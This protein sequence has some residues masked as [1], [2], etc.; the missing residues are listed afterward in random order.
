MCKCRLSQDRFFILTPKDCW[1]RL[2]S[3]GELEIVFNALS[4]GLLLP[5]ICPGAPGLRTNPIGG[6]ASSRLWRSH[7]PMVV[8]DS[9]PNAGKVFGPTLRPEVL[10]RESAPPEA[11]GL[12]GV[13][14][15]GMGV[16]AGTRPQLCLD[17]WVRKISDPWV[18]A[19]VS[20]GYRLQFRRRPPPFS[21]VRMTLVRDPVQAQFLKRE[22]LILLQKDA[23]MKVDPSEQLAG[24]YS[25]YFLVPKK[26]G[27]L[28][29]ILDLRR[30]NTFMKVLPFKMLTTNQVLESLE[31]GEWF[32]SIDLKDAY[33]HVPIFP[34]HWPFL[35]FAFQGQ[36]YQFKVLPFG[37]SLSPRVF[38][39]VVGAALSPL[40]L[41]G[42]KILPY[43][44]DWLVCAPSPSQVSEDTRSLLS[45]IQSLGFT[46]NVKKS[47]LEPRQQAV[48][49]GLCL[50]SVTMSASLTVQRVQSILTLLVQFQLGRRVKLV[51]FQRLLGMISAAVAVVPLGLLRAQPLQRWLNALKLHPKV[52]R[53]VKI[54]VSRTCLQ[55]LCPWQDQ[56]LLVQGVP[57]GLIPSRRTVVTTDASLT[58][59]GGV[60]EGRMVRG[61][62]EPPW[63]EA[64]INVLELRACHL[65]LKALLPFIRDKHVLVRTDSSCT[66]Y[67]INHQGGTR[68][69]QCLQVT[70]EL[71]FWAIQHLASLRAI[72]IPGVLNRAADLLSRSGPPPGEWRLHPE[73]VALLWTRYGRARTDL[74]ASTVTT[75]CKMWFSML[76][77][78]G[79]LGLDALSREWPE[80][81]LY[82]F[83]PF[84]LLPKVLHRVAIG[85]YK[86]LLI[87][88]RWPRRHWF[89][90]LLR[91]VYGEPWALP[92][93]ADLLSQ[94]EGQ[95][96]HPKPAILQLWAW[97]LLSPSLRG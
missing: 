17:S 79:P 13:T 84:P 45:H 54:R 83:P 76:G 44:D 24:F 37:L 33:F 25:T 65:S 42:M 70:Q 72:Y 86:V 60:W 41:S 81:L 47:N 28:R 5:G 87:A 16:D 51:Q 77:Q 38:T 12:M 3:L 71:L 7:L 29:P 26:D 61:V 9:H 18:L 43:L 63:T 69:L 34:A 89:P 39:R 96:W 57:L 75:H 74:F 2:S 67:H 53:H 90:A 36:A 46:V 20:N 31:R 93:R 58:G 40:L 52:D 19:T 94:A 4:A 62:W 56:A 23:I 27:G 32:T 85:H 92:V 68:S 10:L 55:A 15:R 35:R 1:I 22:I 88:P 48:F 82:A 8:M 6:M 11:Q 78:G 73:V 95:I 80:G 59:W 21:R 14:P 66:V 64:H 49:L 91:L 50:N 97:P 30:L